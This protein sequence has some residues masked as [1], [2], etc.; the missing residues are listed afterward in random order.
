MASH[1]LRC[2]GRNPTPSAAGPSLPCA[3]MSALPTGTVAFLMTDIEGS[4]RL[5]SSAGDEFPR[6]LDEHFALLDRA[7][8]GEGG[9]P[10]SS[11]GDALFAVFPS[12]RQAIAAAI[13]AQ[14][15][16]GEHAWPTGATVRVRMGIH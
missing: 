11:E 16:I 13:A 3:A 4:T 9:T 2:R 6:L 14:R 12:A 1:S 10:V 7:V 8:T 15:L 5:V